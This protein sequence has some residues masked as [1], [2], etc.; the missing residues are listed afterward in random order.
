LDKTIPF[1][2]VFGILQLDLIVKYSRC[3]LLLVLREGEL[4]LII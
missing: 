2:H 4:S 1:W 3:P